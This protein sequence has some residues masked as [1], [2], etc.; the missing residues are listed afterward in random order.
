MPHQQEY[1]AW[2]GILVR[3]LALSWRPPLFRTPREKA[4]TLQDALCL[5]HIL[6]D[7]IFLGRTS[8]SRP[9]LSSTYYMMSDA[10]WNL[11]CYDQTSSTVVYFALPSKYKEKEFSSKKNMWLGA[12]LWCVYLHCHGIHHCPGHQGKGPRPPGC[13]LPCAHLDR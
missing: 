12:A 13:P 11:S 1:L 3:S 2:R 7:G 5:V 10:N 6:T 9:S 4:L 8:S